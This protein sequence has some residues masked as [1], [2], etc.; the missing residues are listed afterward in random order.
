M[1]SAITV[2]AATLTTVCT[3][4]TVAQTAD[5]P[6]IIL[7][8]ADDMGWGDAGFNCC[9][10]FPT[11]AIDSIAAG[12]ARYRAVYVGARLPDLTKLRDEASR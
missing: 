11:P 2:F 7:I 3:P 8:L 1:K 10:D 12:G 9:T 6:N 4:I 5:K